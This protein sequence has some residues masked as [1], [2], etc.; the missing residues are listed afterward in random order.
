MR[1]LKSL[2]TTISRK[3]LIVCALLVGVL[4]AMGGY[5]L[6]SKQI[7]SEY[8]PGYTAWRTE[9]KS[10]ADSLLKLSVTTTKERV[11]FNAQLAG[12]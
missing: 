6:W 10:T 4:L 11:A 12:Y 2:H 8:T 1:H 3:Q 7:W 9:I 5:A